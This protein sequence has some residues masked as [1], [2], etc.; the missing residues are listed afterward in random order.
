MKRIFEFFLMTVILGAD[1]YDL[2]LKCLKMYSFR[3]EDI[4]PFALKY[5]IVPVGEGMSFTIIFSGMKFSITVC[6]C[7]NKAWSFIF[8]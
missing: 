5:L 4:V 1:S 7:V 6:S 2:G 8:H 3:M